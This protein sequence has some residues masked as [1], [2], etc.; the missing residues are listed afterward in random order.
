M[1]IFERLRRLNPMQQSKPP[2]KELHLKAHFTQAD[3]V[4]RGPP[5]KFDDIKPTIGKPHA[6]PSRPK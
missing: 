5:E 4:M 1:R 3:M 2:K 6:V